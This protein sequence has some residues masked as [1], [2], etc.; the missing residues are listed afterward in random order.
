MDELNLILDLDSFISLPIVELNI[1]HYYNEGIQSENTSN[2]IEQFYD[3]SQEIV[4]EIQQAYSTGLDHPFFSSDLRWE[5][6]IAH[7]KPF[8]GINNKELKSNRNLQAEIVQAI[9]EYNEGIHRILNITRNSFEL[10]VVNESQQLILK[11]KVLL[12]LSL[13]DISN[14]YTSKILYFNH[15]MNRAQRGCVFF[16]TIK[17]FQLFCFKT[18]IAAEMAKSKNHSTHHQERK[19]H[20]NGIKKPVVH[21]VTSKKGMELTFARNQRY[22][23]IGT[24]VP[25]YVR[26]DLQEVK[27]HA[28][29]RQP[30]KVIVEAAK[31]KMVAKKAAAKK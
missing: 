23:R 11:R 6:I 22:A 28:A 18:F 4:N 27:P 19:N 9:N 13:R 24:E 12:A 7:Y 30:L 8:R 20:R 16:L 17:N 10:D 1:P 2:R 26:G 21:R 3:Q 5:K 14:K 15:S 25:R 29:P 31:A